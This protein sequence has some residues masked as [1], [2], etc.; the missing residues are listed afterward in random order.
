[1]N[2]HEDAVPPG[3]LRTMQIIT[4]AIC[5]GLIFF[6]AIVLYLVLVQNQGQG[7]TKPP[8]QVPVVSLLA[9]GLLVVTGVMS[10]VLPAAVAR[11]NLRRIAAGTWSPPRGMTPPPSTDAGK[12]L[13]LRQTT[14]IIGLALLEGTGFM[15]CIG[16]MLEGQALA[17]LVVAV[18]LGL[19]LARFPTEGR[20]RGWLDEQQDQLA[21]LRQEAG[22]AGPGR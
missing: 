22:P 1:M 18:A 3:T 15:G 2:H 9:A 19:M 20:V 11:S 21:R 14:L 5:M 16:Y 6:G 13:I 12:L 17:L 8:P 4:F 7:L 10:F